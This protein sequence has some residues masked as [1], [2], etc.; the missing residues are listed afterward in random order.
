MDYFFNEKVIQLRGGKKNSAVLS[1]EKEEVKITENSNKDISDARQMIS[2]SDETSLQQFKTEFH[3]EVLQVGK[4]TDE[5]NAV[6][7]RM[8]SIA[9]QMEPE[10]IQYLEQVL[11]DRKQ[12]GDERAM[13]VELLSRN[14]SEQAENILK[15]FILQDQGAV[16]NNKGQRQQEQ[17]I[18]FKAQAIEGIAGR[19]DKSLARK[20]LDEIANKS[21]QSFLV[22]RAKRAKAQIDGQLRSLDS[23]DNEALKKLIE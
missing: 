21:S 12:G 18:I 15:N 9:R 23:Q 16:V 2:V 1:R 13:A 22:D 6:E 5:P 7:N 10:H 8:Q 14:Q 3:H 11:L 20:H 17:E 19:E 4:T